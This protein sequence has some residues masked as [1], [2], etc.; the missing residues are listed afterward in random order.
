[1]EMIINYCLYQIVCVIAVTARLS[2]EYDLP[3]LLFMV[4]SLSY[5]PFTHSFTFPPSYNL[6][7]TN[8]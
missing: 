5:N 1:M 2:H 6:A 7:Q 3:S 8:K 4:I